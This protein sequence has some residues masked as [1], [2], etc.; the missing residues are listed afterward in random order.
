MS[1]QG[2][3]VGEVKEKYYPFHAAAWRLLSCAT[4]HAGCSSMSEFTTIFKSEKYADTNVCS[5]RRQQ[6]VRRA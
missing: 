2:Y 1:L 5:H 4:G 6:T 3:A